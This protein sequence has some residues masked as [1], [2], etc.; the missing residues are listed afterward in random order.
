MRFWS[1]VLLVVATFCLVV[2]ACG[3]V[4]TQ[5]TGP[6]YGD[7]GGDVTL[8]PPGNLADGGGC[9]PKACMDLGYTCGKNADGCGNMID[10][11]SCTSPAFCGGGGFSQCGGNSQVLD[12]GGSI[13]VPQSC[14]SLGYGCGSNSD[15][16]GN[17]LNCGAC[18]APEFCGG[19]GFSKCGGN[20]VLADAG[21]N[22]CVPKTCLQQ[23]LACGPAGDGCGNQIA[24]GTC[25][26]PQFCGGGGPSQCGGNLAALDGGGGVCTP[27]SCATQS[28]NCGPT[29]DGCGNQLSCGTC[30]PPQFCGAAASTCAAATASSPRAAASACPRRAHSSASTAARRTTDVATCSSAEA[31]SRPRSAG[32]A[33][34]PACA[35]TAHARASA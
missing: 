29:G 4:G 31:A 13:C 14:V 11:G 33:G 6:V 20:S 9:K 12:A 7:G 32:V 19:G 17:V 23:G 10:C 18:A 15:G 5:A 30:T 16:C 24:C 21:G 25:T 3:G 34:T 22:A 26:S 1:P 27:T 35:A 2:A 28:F 8:P